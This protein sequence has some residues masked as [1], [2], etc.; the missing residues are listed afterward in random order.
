MSGTFALMFRFPYPMENPV[1]IIPMGVAILTKLP[2]TKTLAQYY[3]GDPD[4]LPV[5]VKYVEGGADNMAGVLL[6]VSIDVSG[7]SYTLGTTHF[8][9]TDKGAAD[10]RQRRD[11]KSLFEKLDTFTDGIV[12]AGDLNAPRG[13]E[14]FD[15][16]AKRFK[17]NIPPEYETSL[18]QDL[19]RAPEEVKHL[20][21]DGL[22]STPEYSVTNASLNFGV[23]DHAAIVADIAK[24]QKEEG[25]F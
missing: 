12:F 22:F 13:R 20:M 16:I 9:W 11:L 18:D 4:N 24:I 19:H 17:D 25:T 15:E 7:I 3:K 23:S 1:E 14:I 6:S 10:D 5:F 2:V 8:T 21:V